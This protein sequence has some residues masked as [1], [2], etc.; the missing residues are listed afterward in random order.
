[1][2]EAELDWDFNRLH[3]GFALCVNAVR[4]VPLS[5]IVA[6][7]A[8]QYIGKPTVVSMKRYS[9]PAAMQTTNGERFYFWE[10]LTMSPVR[11]L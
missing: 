6:E 11:W 9:C 7:T 4:T 3:C 8:C 5:V 10:N 1:M 2:S